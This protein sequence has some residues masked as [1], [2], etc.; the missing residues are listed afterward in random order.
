[1]TTILFAWFLFMTA[2]TAVLLDCL[3]G[4]RYV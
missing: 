4:R 2:A 3:M 1:M